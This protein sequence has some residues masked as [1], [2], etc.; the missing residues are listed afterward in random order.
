MYPMPPDV[1]L[2]RSPDVHLQRIL[3]HD[4]LDRLRPRRSVLGIRRRDRKAR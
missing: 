4:H 2:Q 3:A 1:H